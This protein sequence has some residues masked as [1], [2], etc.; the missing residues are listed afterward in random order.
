MS[1]KRYNVT[2]YY[3]ATGMEGRADEKDLGVFLA[4][5]TDDAKTQAIELHYSNLPPD[6]QTF[7]R[8]CLTVTKL[9]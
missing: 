5:D 9:N 2:Y 1:Q 8:S 4:V 7:V 3:L 6:S